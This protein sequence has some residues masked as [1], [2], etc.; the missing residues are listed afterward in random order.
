VGRSSAVGELT[1]GI[2]IPAELEGRTMLRTLTETVLLIAGL[3]LDEVVAF[4][5]AIDEI[6]TALIETAVADSVIDCKIRLDEG[7]IAVRVAAV[8]NIRDPIDEQGLGWY[9]VRTVTESSTADI[10]SFDA[11]AGGYPVT[12]EFDRSSGSGTTG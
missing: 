9:V 8:A 2:G 5:L 7:R 12:V 1:V 10:G 3:A 4:E 11:A 6:T